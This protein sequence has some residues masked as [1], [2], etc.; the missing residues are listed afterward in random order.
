M[1]Q[2]ACSG[3]LIGMNTAFLDEG[4][5]IYSG[6]QELG[7]LL[8]GRP[9]AEYQSFFSGAPVIY[10]VVVATADILGG[11][12]GTRL[13]SMVFMLSATVAVHLAARR[14]Y[15]SL[16]AFFA[17]ALFAA[18][19]P[20]QFLGGYATYDAMALALLA[21]AGYFA[22]R[23]ATGGGYLCILPAAVAMALAD[24]TKYASLLW[25][26]VVL[27]LAVFAGW[28]GSPWSGVRWRRGL[29]LFAVWVV[30]L[31]IPAA[32][33]GQV[34]LHGFTSTTLQRKVASD[35]YGY[36]ATAAAQWVGALLV[37][38]LIGTVVVLCSASRWGANGR[39]AR[40][41][42][43]VLL[44]GGVLAPA[45]Q[46]RI[47]T[48]LSLQKHVDFG[49]WFSCMVAGYLLA[50]LLPAAASRARLAAGGL[51]AA[52]AVGALGWVG[53]GQATAMFTAWPDSV[54]WSPP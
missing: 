16:A 6:Y 49:A 28:G 33:A 2:A 8:H 36:V 34:Y 5:Y 30:A 38:A 20:T 22:T 17:A 14:I 19:G 11:L 46:I 35:S 48:W 53:F 52:T 3:R 9:V 50:R 45:N 13:L 25:S 21:W 4:T 12:S 24:A 40:W 51:A 27:G 1:V 47:H 10:P 29:L 42:A 23:L 26:P 31:A 32:A 54:R 15:G 37:L 7:H 39:S 44:V 18:L 43:L 41:L